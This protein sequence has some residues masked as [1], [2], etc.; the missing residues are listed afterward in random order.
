MSFSQTCNV[1]TF[2]HQIVAK[3]GHTFRHRAPGWK[4]QTATW[5]LLSG[6]GDR[7]MGACV[8]DE[9]VERGKKTEVSHHNDKFL[10][11]RRDANAVQVLTQGEQPC[12]Q[13]LQ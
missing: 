8:T 11:L 1:A 6:Q 5:G 4:E 9:R 12:L 2:V 13:I 3:Q 7:K 10:L